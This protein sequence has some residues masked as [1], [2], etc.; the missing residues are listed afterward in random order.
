[1]AGFFVFLTD[2]S[3]GE[4][5]ALSSMP[6]HFVT[7][8]ASLGRV[9]NF[10]HKYIREKLYKFRPPSVELKP[11]ATARQIRLVIWEL[12][13]PIR[14][15][16]AYRALSEHDASVVPH[17]EAAI[18][19]SPF[20]SIDSDHRRPGS[21]PIG[22]LLQLLVEFGSPKAHQVISRLLQ[23]SDFNR[24]MIGIQ[25]GLRILHPGAV[26]VAASALRSEKEHDRHSSVV[27]AIYMGVSDRGDQHYRDAVYPLVFEVLQSDAFAMFFPKLLLDLDPDRAIADLQSAELLSPQSRHSAEILRLLR[28]QGVAVDEGRILGLLAEAEKTP[29]DHASQ[30]IIGEV[31]MMLASIRHPNTRQL[32]ERFASSEQEDLSEAAYR[33]MGLLDNLDPD[34]VVFEKARASGSHSLTPL[35]RMYYEVSILDGQVCNGGFLQYFSNSYGEGVNMALKGLNA[36]GARKC[37]DIVKKAIACFGPAGVSPDRDNRNTALAKMLDDGRASFDDSAWYENKD[38]LR[39]LMMQFALD[40]PDDFRSA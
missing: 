18:D 10:F 7:F 31:L 13:D 25:Q 16:N 17:L 1:L 8:L 22:A 12:I 30:R 5:V 2:P 26:D 15:A 21:S 33:A 38:H 9:A 3:K 4:D 6:C 28:R 24:K 27:H 23:D 36:M 14:A 20:Q 34:R 37:A 39:T 11:G 40:H 35:Q 32:A 19:Q 29:Q